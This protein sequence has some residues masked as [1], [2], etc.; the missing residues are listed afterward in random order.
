MLSVS[1]IVQQH[2]AALHAT[3]TVQDL[4]QPQ[5]FLEETYGGREVIQPKQR[6][7]SLRKKQQQ[8]QQQQQQPQ[9]R[10]PQVA[11]AEAMVAA[12]ATEAEAMVA[13]EATEAE[14]AE[15][16]EAAEA[17]A[18]VLVLVLVLAVAVEVANLTEDGV[19]H[20]PKNASI[21]KAKKPI[22]NRVAY[23]LHEKSMMLRFIL[24]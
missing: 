1:E 17:M 18:E 13:A 19:A 4:D 3:H 24:H 20:T 23:K 10:A 11:A 14:A 15:A 8:Q 6:L 7:K 2:L 9:Q 21:A 5:M 16:T 12:E 22:V